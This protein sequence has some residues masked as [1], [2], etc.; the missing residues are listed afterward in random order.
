MVNKLTW[1][2]AQVFALLQSPVGTVGRDLLRRGRLVET[3]AKRQVGVRSGR[4]Q[5][6]IQITKRIPTPI[7][8][9]LTVGSDVKYALIHHNGSRPHVIL[10]VT[11][12]Q[13]VFTSGGRV[14]RTSR[15]NHPGTKPNRFLTDN[16]PFALID[17]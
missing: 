14:I 6:S 11:A 5:K 8:Q 15:V 13:L 9:K 1:R 3:A 17:P 7:G 4:L 16:L 12:K 10:P 2:N